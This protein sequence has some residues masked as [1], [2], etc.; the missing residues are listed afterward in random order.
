MMKGSP[1]RLAMETRNSYPSLFFSLPK[2]HPMTEKSLLAMVKCLPF[3]PGTLPRSSQVM[4][5]HSEGAV[6]VCVTTYQ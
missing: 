4:Y 2:I 3:V 5:A 1:E 6:N